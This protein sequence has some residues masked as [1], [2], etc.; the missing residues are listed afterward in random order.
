MPH[1][2]FNTLTLLL[3]Q[4]G[5]ILVVSRALGL[6]TRRLGQPMVIAEVLAGIL[7]GPSLLGLIWP[8]GM[9]ALFPPAS[10]GGLKMLADVGLV[11]FMFLVG[12][13]LDPQLLK[14]KTRTS[15]IISQASIVAPFAL[16]AAAAPWIHA[17]YA[18]AGVALTPFL[19]FLGAAMS[20]TAF[21]VLARILSERN[22]LTSRVGAMA[23]ACAAADD[24]A[25]WCILAFVVSVA[26]ASGLDGA[27]WTT[28]LAAIYIAFMVGGVR[29]FLARLAL[30]VHG[31]EG[32][33][34]GRVAMLLVL[35]IA[36]ATITELIGIH[37][38]FGAFLMGAIIPKT[39]GLATGLIDRLEAVPVLMLLP[40]FF[41]YS[42]L[43]TQIGLVDS[44]ADWLVTA[45]VI[46]IATAGKFGGATLA[47]R[48]TGMSGREASAI[49]ILMNTRGLMELIVLN[50]GMDLGV[51]SPT[52]FTMLVLMALVTTVATA[53]VL[54]LVYPDHELA[55]DRAVPALVQTAE[56][57]APYT[58]LLC[59]ADRRVGNAMATVAATLVGQRSAP[60]RYFALHLWAPSASL[61]RDIRREHDEAAT[62]PLAD[63]LGRASGLGLDM[64]PLGFMSAEPAVDICRTAEA[65]QAGLILLGSH[66]P[67]LLEGQFGGTVGEV[68]GRARHPVAVLVD[69][70]LD[71]LQRVLVAFVG[72]VEDQ[73]ALQLAQRIG[74][75][76]G[77]SLTILHVTAPDDEA[78]HGRAQLDELFPEDRLSAKALRL[79]TVSHD[80]PPD[81]VLEELGRGYDLLVLGLGQHWGLSTSLIGRRKGR[82]LTESPV[83]VLAVH[84]PPTEAASAPALVGDA[85]DATVAATL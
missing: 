82:V 67:L 1:F 83:S 80:S 81:A 85:A 23:I 40:L 74:Q 70:G 61:T 33:S 4:I 45:V 6:I 47:A 46:G 59:I 7:L 35:L 79:K 75:A 65:K 84:A 50:L 73:A 53:P 19:L 66:K 20:V 77:V 12:L 11:L 72:G 44:A 42:G 9:A 36:S 26:R 3:V 38:L 39:G 68:V 71:R 17:R 48:L 62:S 30:R 16:A 29:P 27:L 31:N 60:T 54:R 5:A 49:G 14:G 69:R 28:G 37:A 52:L 22:L 21:P 18:P 43:R 78:V 34:Q 25:A 15:L 8:D 76:P 24:V 2:E 58:V 41:A 13:E 57:L 10:L 63:L 32:L 55:R 56:P 51:I 64:R